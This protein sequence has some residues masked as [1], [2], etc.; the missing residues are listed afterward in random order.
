MGVRS[1]SAAIG[2]DDGSEKNWPHSDGRTTQQSSGAQSSQGAAAAGTQAAIASQVKG[3]RTMPACT[4][5]SR[6]GHD[7]G[8]MLAGGVRDADVGMNETARASSCVDG[9]C[10]HEPR[11][12]AAIASSGEPAASHCCGGLRPMVFCV[13][14]DGRRAGAWCSSSSTGR[15]VHRCRGVSPWASAA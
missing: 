12:R 7:L 11:S 9:L 13:L 10:S 5:S 15:V 2:S 14:R 6:R 4:Q 3:I 1:N 8:G